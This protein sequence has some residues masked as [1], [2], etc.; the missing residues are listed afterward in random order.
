MN[1]KS[2]M[3]VALGMIAIFSSALSIA[4]DGAA[5]EIPKCWLADQP[6]AKIQDGLFRVVLQT[7]GRSARDVAKLLSLTA[8][9]TMGSQTLASSDLNYK[10]VE[11][12]LDTSIVKSWRRTE[13]YPTLESF[14]AEILKSFQPIVDMPGVT[15]SCIPEMHAIPHP[16]GTVTN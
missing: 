16:G 7:K 11:V 8:F 4:A 6:D 12:E 13:T 9:G 14:K 2:L 3:I 5:A 10:T 1:S 15:L